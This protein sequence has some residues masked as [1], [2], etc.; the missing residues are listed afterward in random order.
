MLPHVIADLATSD[1]VLRQ[2]EYQIIL[3]TYEGL[4]AS[5]TDKAGIIEWYD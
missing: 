1:S 4:L 5:Y 3:S 2:R